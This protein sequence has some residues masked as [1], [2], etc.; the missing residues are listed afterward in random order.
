MHIFRVQTSTSTH[1]MLLKRALAHLCLSQQFSMDSTET[2]N[3]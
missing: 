2:R 3:K 1:K